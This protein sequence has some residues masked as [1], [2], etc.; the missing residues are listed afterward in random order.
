VA[1]NGCRDQGAGVGRAWLQ[2]SNC[3][4]RGWAI[5]PASAVPSAQEGSTN[6]A[7][8]LSEVRPVIA[9]RAGSRSTMHATLDA[10]CQLHN[11][12]AGGNAAQVGI[13]ADGAALPVGPLTPEPALKLDLA[14]DPT[15][16]LEP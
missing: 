14:L 10:F 9:Y 1:A 12:L 7:C 3:C 11:S 15:K 16:P 13:A 8:Q 4:L 2:W 5:R 6:A